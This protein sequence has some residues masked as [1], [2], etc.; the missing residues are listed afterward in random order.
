VFDLPTKDT[1]V[2][3]YLT[4]PTQNATSLKTNGTRVLATRCLGDNSSVINTAN[5]SDTSSTLDE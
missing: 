4:L 3:P 5:Q 2:P 1:Y